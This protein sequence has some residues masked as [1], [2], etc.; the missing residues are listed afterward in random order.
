MFFYREFCFVR[1][2]VNRL[3]IVIFKYF[4]IF[5]YAVGKEKLIPKLQKK[6]RNQENYNIFIMELI[7]IDL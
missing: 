7:S 6:G 4:V 2:F 1:G 5:F 3:F